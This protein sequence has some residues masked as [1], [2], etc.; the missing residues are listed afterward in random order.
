MSGVSRLS[1]REKDSGLEVTGADAGR[2][3]NGQRVLPGPVER[4]TG[5]VE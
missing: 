2:V 1:G 3:S 5:S 4:G